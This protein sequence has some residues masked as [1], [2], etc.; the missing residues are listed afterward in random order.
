[1]VSSRRDA[2]LE[3]IG[4]STA[5]VALHLVGWGGAIAAAAL[6]HPALTGLAAL[7]YGLGIR[8]AFDADH[9]AAIDNTIRRLVTPTSQACASVSSGAAA[10][11]RPL[12]VGL[13]F[14]LGHSSVVLA[15]TLAVAL[16]ARWVTPAMPFLQAWGHLVGTVVAGVVLYGI[17][18]ANLVVLVDTLRMARQSAGGAVDAAGL[19]APLAGGGPIARWCGGVRRL[20][21]RPWHMWLVGALFGLG[22]DTATEIAL[23]ATAG[24]A[25]ANTLPLAA[26][27]CL[28]VVFAA[29]M[30]LMDAA[31]G[32]IMCRVYGWGVGR[33]GDRL[34]YNVALTGASVA[35]ALAVGGAEMLGLAAEYART[36]QPRVA[37]LV[38]ALDLSLM[39]PA[40]AL[41]FTLVW[42]GSMAV[43]RAKVQ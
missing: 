17:A 20:V 29:G 35:L 3:L 15:M 19:D 13:Y 22:F 21:R 41:G 39:G 7:A 34:R 2:Q 14:S 12:G 36:L 5:V 8:H 16:A 42:A 27:L 37:G 25:A 24:V 43:Q 26:V 33:P 1:M 18:L 10:G 23:L 30:S 28:P 31:N 9:I 11:A 40:A 32:I 4:I 6:G 38:G